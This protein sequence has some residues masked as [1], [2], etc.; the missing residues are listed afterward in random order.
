M[1]TYDNIILAES[2]LVN[3][4]SF[5]DAA[6]LG[7]DS[8]GTNTGTVV[9]AASL[10]QVDDFDGKALNLNGGAIS[11]ARQIQDDFTIEFWLKTANSAP[12][13][14]NFWSGWGLTGA[15][16]GGYTNDFG[17]NLVSGGNIL[18]GVYDSP[19]VISAADYNDGNWHHVVMTRI[20]TSGVFELFVDKVSQG[21]QVQ[22]A[23][24]SLTA[25][26][27]IQIGRF[28]TTGYYRG[29][30]AKVAF[31]NAAL[32][33]STID[34]HYDFINSPPVLPIGITET[35][36]TSTSESFHANEITAFSND[37]SCK[38][39]WRFESGALTVDSQGENTLTAVNAPTSELI[40][41][42]EGLGSTH[43]VR[44][45]GQCYT[46]PDASLPAD[47]PF[48]SGGA[49]RQGTYLGW[50]KFSS[51]AG[52]QGLIGKLRVVGSC[53]VYQYNGIFHLDWN[54]SWQSTSLP[55]AINV[56]Y[57][58]AV[59]MDGN[60]GYSNLRI[61]RSSDSQ[62]LT[63]AKND[64]TVL[65]PGATDFKIGSFNSAGTTF[66][67]LTDEVVVFNRLLSDTEIDAI[68]T[69]TFPVPPLLKVSQVGTQ[70]E[71]E[72]PPLIKVS[73]VGTQIEWE[74]PPLLK[75]G[76]IIAQ[77]E[78]SPF[79]AGMFLVF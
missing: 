37:P 75:V 48:K 21:T 8:K 68:R 5:L 73:Q 51:T 17:I 59:R 70:I 30:L 29:I 26:S 12:V 52:D 35:A 32:A 56:W 44:A 65:T 62:V 19:F 34:S 38:A 49:N 74:D 1:P 41:F 45:S 71:W 42:K 3:F 25:P 13:G 43:L 72:D 77:V 67:G 24:V 64:W 66:D 53:G 18:A 79:K 63:Y 15:E 27:T 2:S 10:S 47:F 50:F 7:A 57:H 40:D 78:Y 20:K 69:A 76:Q 14:T 23:G 31:Y 60:A 33:K 4:Y 22:R 11:I 55:V 61:F 58:V 36:S 9:N 46:I 6:N 54:N 39:L 16:V 28:L